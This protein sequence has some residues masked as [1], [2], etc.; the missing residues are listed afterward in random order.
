MTEKSEAEK[1]EWEG[2]TGDNWAA[3]YNKTDRSLAPLTQRLLE[4]IGE[5]PGDAVLDIGCGAGEL[6][7]AIA[8]ARPQATVVGVDL[9]PQLVATASKRAE[10]RANVT[11]ENGDAA[12]WR[13]EG[14]SPELL[15]SRHGVM[16]FP[17]P[18]AA[19]A[20]LRSQAGPGAALVFSCFRSPP[21]NKWMVETAQMAPDAGE[22]PPPDPNA[23][24][25]FAF[26]DPN[27]V[28][29]LLGDA[30][31]SQV[32]FEPVD[33]AFVAGVGDDPVEDSM[34]LFTHVGPAARA[35]SGLQGD[36]KELALGRFREWAEAHRDGDV[37]AFS[38]SV[39]IVSARNA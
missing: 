21:E 19:F 11:F 6:S 5:Y 7:L 26:A 36:D 24:G 25:P 12:Q 28:E 13:K 4:R 32:E 20:H 38:T 39:W 34:W 29:S 37:V 22:G 8:R 16:F 30:G 18:V 15:V 14:F 2:Q 3:M 27:R 35:V 23:P 31:W 1:S 33:F 10:Q 17:D 9:S